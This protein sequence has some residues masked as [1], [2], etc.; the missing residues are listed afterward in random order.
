MGQNVP[1]KDPLPSTPFCVAIKPMDQ[2]FLWGCCVSGNYKNRSGQWTMALRR[3]SNIRNYRGGLKCMP[4]V[5]EF[6]SRDCGYTDAR[7]A[8]PSGRDLPVHSIL[9]KILARLEAL[10]SVRISFVS[11]KTTSSTTRHATATG[12]FQYWMLLYLMLKEE[13]FFTVNV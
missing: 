1:F 11:S 9:A 5:D 3:F 13:P 2:V 6:A 12:F 10:T 8:K 7:Y 4:N